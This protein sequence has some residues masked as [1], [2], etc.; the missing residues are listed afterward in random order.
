MPP[1]AS[2]YSGLFPRDS[3]LSPWGSGLSP[4][5]SRLS[6]R[7]SGLSPWDSGHCNLSSTDYI[8][9]TSVYVLILELWILGLT[10]GLTFS[11]SKT[12]T[13]LWQLVYSYINIS[14]WF[15]NSVLLPKYNMV[16]HLEVRFHQGWLDRHL[17]GDNQHHHTLTPANRDR[18][19]ILWPECQDINSSSPIILVHPSANQVIL[20]LFQNIFPLCIFKSS[21]DLTSS[22]NLYCFFCFSCEKVRAKSSAMC[23]SS[24]CSAR[25]HW[26]QFLVVILFQ[27]PNEQGWQSILTTLCFK[28]LLKY[29]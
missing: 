11:I 12:F 13:A 18:I 14:A 16:L 10:L 8:F 5:D 28:S 26:I 1:W 4:W 23:R 19:H 24:D 6:P 21:C 2:W 3:G 29:S 22:L 15:T 7:D 20:M 17:L 25:V 27:N 9:H